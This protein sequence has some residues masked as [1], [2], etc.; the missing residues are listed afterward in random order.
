MTTIARR[1]Q[2]VVNRV[3]EGGVVALDREVVDADQQLALGDQPPGEVE[4]TATNSVV[5]LGLGRRPSV[6]SCGS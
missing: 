4:A 3:L 2:G 1:Q 5:E 6:P